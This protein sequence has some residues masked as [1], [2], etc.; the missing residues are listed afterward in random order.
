MSVR[1]FRCLSLTFLFVS[2]LFALAGCGGGGGGGGG[3]N[4]PPV[5]TSAAG[6]NLRMDGTPLYFGRVA[7][8]DGIFVSPSSG[9]HVLTSQDGVTWTIRKSG[10][11]RP[12]TA[13]A[14]G[15]GVFVAVGKEGAVVT[16]GDGVAWTVRDPQTTG[17]FAD[18][19]FGNG[20]FVA[21]ASGETAPSSGHEILRSVDGI[22][23]TSTPVGSRF[24]SVSFGNGIFVAV[25]EGGAIV[26]S[27]DARTWTP[28]DSGTSATLGRVVQ[29]NSF[30]VASGE[31]LPP[32]TDLPGRTAAQRHSPEWP[33]ATE[34][35]TRCRAYSIGPG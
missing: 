30:F 17:S 11:T 7:F 16:S 14:F 2:A 6:W 27:A 29:G 35:F 10:A 19:V 32:Q 12:L 33:S 20:V 5:E 21:L 31:S 24:L 18:V 15:N 22:T 3:G 8:G 26:A 4:T 28:G 13:A 34:G 9:G 23:W 25:G 1:G